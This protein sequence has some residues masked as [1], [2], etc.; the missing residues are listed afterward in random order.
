VWA[1]LPTQTLPQRGARPV[2]RLV[3]LAQALSAD[4]VWPGALSKAAEELHR[5]LD[6]YAIRHSDRLGSAIQE[7]RD[8]HVKQIEGRFGET[9]LSYAEFVERAD[10]RAIRTSFEATKKAFGADIAQSY[11][12]HLA[13]PDDDYSDDE[14]REA[15]VRTAALANV[16]EVRDKVDSEALD[17]TSRLFAQHRVAIRGHSGHG[18]GTSEGS[19]ATTANAHRGFLCRGERT[20]HRS[21][22]SSVAPYV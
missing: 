4:G 21:A 8:V 5:I 3:V 11:V 7:V 17:F 2:K 10:D 15:F 22:V 20:D 9:G 18:Y 14:L 19:A 13:G 16:K 6:A 12:N 1:E